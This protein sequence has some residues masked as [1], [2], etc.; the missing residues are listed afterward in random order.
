MFFFQINMIHKFHLGA[1]VIVRP[2]W[3][4]GRKVLQEMSWFKDIRQIWLLQI[5]RI[6][7]LRC[8][9]L[10]NFLFGSFF[11]VWQHRKVLDTPPQTVDTCDNPPSCN[12]LLITTRTTY[13][14]T[15]PHVTFIYYMG[16]ASMVYI[17]FPPCGWMFMVNLGKSYTKNM[18]PIQKHCF[19]MSLLPIPLGF[20]VRQFSAM[21]WSRH[22]GEGH[23]LTHADHETW[24]HP[25]DLE[26]EPRLD[27][28]WKRH[29]DKKH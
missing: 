2:L 17:Y 11:F 22:L 26:W 25:R 4:R 9:R 8:L 13:I 3:Q 15:P 21:A 5:V 1:I 19:L 6:V 20:S 18:D 12:F 10:R 24:R 14:H 7:A 16:C 29:V 27:H 28:T 23:Q